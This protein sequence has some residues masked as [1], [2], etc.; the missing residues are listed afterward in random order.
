[1]EKAG[2]VGLLLQRER[3]RVFFK[4]SRGDA[5]PG[6]RPEDQSWTAPCKPGIWEVTQSRCFLTL[7]QPRISQAHS[8]PYSKR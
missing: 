6:V 1:M 4:L 2:G 5:A 7:V 3:Q 8:L